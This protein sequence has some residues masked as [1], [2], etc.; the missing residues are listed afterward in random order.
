MNSLFKTITR[1]QKTVSNETV[2][3][4]EQPT[5]V[6]Q[7]IFVN[8]LE[9]MMFIG[10]FDNEKHKKQLVNISMEVNVIANQHWQEDDVKNVVSYADI[11]NAALEI[12]EQENHIDL[13]E[14]YAEM[15]IERCFQNHM[16][17][18]MKVKLSK[19]G[20]IDNVGSVGAIIERTK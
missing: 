6:K 8:D 19:P 18:G 17:L 10:V 4:F 1:A 9:V 11:V 14:T 13:I 2:V 5:T 12:A 15:I 7:T 3:A 16:V 20:I